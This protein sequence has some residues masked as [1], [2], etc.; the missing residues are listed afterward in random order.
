MLF[1]LKQNFFANYSAVMQAILSRID[2]SADRVIKMVKHSG[3][4]THSK[5]ADK[6]IKKV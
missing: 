5:P 3:Q 6:R 1:N 4:I 2:A